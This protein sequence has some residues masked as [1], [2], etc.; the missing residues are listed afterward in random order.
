[1]DKIATNN[2][3]KPYLSRTAV[4]AL[5]FGSAVGWGAFVMPGNT[6]LP[7][8]GP[9]GT[10]TGIILGAVLM[11]VIAANY[12]YM[13]AK[14]PDA[15]GAF[16]Y[17]CS[18]FDRD[19][20]FLNAWFLILTYVAVVWAN[21]TALALIVRNVFG[22]ALMKGPHYS[23]F[24]YEV[25]LLEIVMEIAVLIL[26]G[27]ICIRSGKATA[28]IQIFFAV[29]LIVGIVICA[30]MVFSKN[31]I[32]ISRFKPGFADEEKKA[33][34]ILNIML[35]AP[36][37]FIGFESVSHSVEEFKFPVKKT[38]GIMA[39][40]VITATAAYII[41]S[42]M[43]GYVRPKGY[44]DWKSY[45]FDAGSLDNIES[46]P[47]FYA[48]R[49][50]AGRAGLVFLGAVVLSGIITGIIGNI[51]A[52]S[53]LL[54]AISADDTIPAGF[55][56][57]NSRGM[58]KK[59]IVFIMV[60]SGII[61]FFG[62]TA[63]GWVVDVTTVGAAL[64][65]G[66]TSASA[67]R[68]AANDG[69]KKVMITG[70]IGVVSSAMFCLVLLVPNIWSMSTLAAESYLVLAVWSILGFIVFRFVFMH[71]TKNRYGKSTVTWFAIVFL[72]FFTSL[73]WMRIAMHNRTG[74]LVDDISDYYAEEMVEEG[75]DRE[76][77]DINEE[78]SYLKEQMVKVS[79]SLMTNSFVQFAL[80]VIAIIVMLNVYATVMKR[81]K[82]LEV[83]MLKAKENSR[84]KS[85]FLSNMS[86]DIR[87]PMNAIIGYT[88]LAKRDDIT[89]P[90]MKE[91]IGK[92]EDSSQHL[93]A[94]INDVLEMSRIE[95]GK[96]ELELS[97][98]DLRKL[99]SGVK[100]LFANQMN[101]K[102]LE[103]IVDYD[104]LEHCTVRCD[105]NRINRVLLNLIS[106]AM[107]F[108][109]EHGRVTVTLKETGMLDENRAEYELS[110]K[111]SGIGMTEDFAAKVFEA[112]ERERT[113]TVS[114][115]QGT[116]LGMAIS[117]SIVEL[118]NGSVRVDTAPGKGTCFIV[119]LPLE[120][121][122]ELC[123]EDDSDSAALSEDIR[124]DG[125]R[126][127]LVE[128]IEMNREIA[129]YIL[130]DMGFEVDTAENGREA[131]AKVSASTAGYYDVVLMDIQMPVMDGY[132]ATRH[133]R[134]LDDK[135]LGNVPIIAMT[136]NAFAEDIKKAT[137]A[138]MNAH[139][140]KPI[141]V[142]TLKEALQRILSEES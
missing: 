116:G 66:Y 109:P 96:M 117:K 49:E 104:R 31:G 75:I 15:G 32:E 43:A 7:I 80:I 74:K 57:L 45:I 25:Y 132:E 88:T 28:L 123:E 40:A 10:V 130:E 46:M 137:D 36:W 17:T 112:F 39:A 18:A 73:M 140:A 14:Y 97:A 118:M 58:P 77:V 127:L 54:Y 83:D 125:K 98:A 64:A 124:F 11:I 107:K 48:V 33:V 51:T 60:I 126:V 6:F 122:G 68:Q 142:A 110:V 91:Y 52:A 94:L 89:V 95:S 86:H 62:R 1:M 5:S 65:Y 120:V 82:K 20:G 138:G 128:D 70:I 78:Q 16:F 72:I 67:Y 3:L 35:L 12:S 38:F 84:A 29:F 135:K 21:V 22:D 9:L 2:R 76:D 87:T 103:Y 42:L 56:K 85:T 44:S 50:S 141:D 106:N 114:G 19:H 108:T 129:Y 139:V 100:D 23:V 79:N 105:V 93:L 61:P 37:A 134:E 115:I 4:W 8:A 119:R 81:E 92:I 47:V 63:T 34:S 24:G 99:M 41:P 27:L 90:E 55:D 136:A 131:Y 59:A 69:N 133:I 111:D 53:R 113:S 13:T 121:T 30:W 101:E 26:C 102:H 71:D